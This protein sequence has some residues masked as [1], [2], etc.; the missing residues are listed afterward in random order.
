MVPTPTHNTTVDHSWSLLASQQRMLSKSHKK[1]VHTLTSNL[2]HW[3][4]CRE[5]LSCFTIICGLSEECNCSLCYSLW[6]DFDLSCY[7]LQVCSISLNHWWQG[8]VIIIIFLALTFS[9]NNY[10]KFKGGINK[11]TWQLCY[12]K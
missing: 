9:S 12:C 7:N 8:L 4:F 10:R 5:Q 11:Q 1:Y 6:P 3:P 2:Q